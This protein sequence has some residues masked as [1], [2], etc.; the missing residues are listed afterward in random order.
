[1]KVIDDYLGTSTRGSLSHLGCRTRAKPTASPPQLA[2]RWAQQ[3]EPRGPPPPSAAE[4]AGGAPWEGV[5]AR[6]TPPRLAGEKENPASSAA[7]RPALEPVALSEQPL[8]FSPP[9]RAPR[10]RLP[11][12]SLAWVW[13]TRPHQPL[14]HCLPRPLRAAALRR[15]VPPWGEGRASAGWKPE[16]NCSAERESPLLQDARR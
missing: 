5:K 11:L 1:M 7:R 13:T 12:L 16:E 8:R 10:V 3:T 4:A 15:A 2:N 9:T 14:P 6:N